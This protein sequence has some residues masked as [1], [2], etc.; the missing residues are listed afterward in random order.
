MTGL[1][2][3]GQ[4]AS[5]TARRRRSSRFSRG[6]PPG[7]SGAERSPLGGPAA[8]VKGIHPARARPPRSTTALQRRLGAHQEPGR[9]SIRGEQP[10]TTQTNSSNGSFSCP[11]SR[12]CPAQPPG[13][14]TTRRSARA[15]TTPKPSSASHD[16]DPTCSTRCSARA[17]STPLNPPRPLDVS[18][19]TR[20][21]RDGMTA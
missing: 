15:S 18:R 14:T 10:S 1:P 3:W 16:T 7:P 13:P 6:S 12:P 11:R 9:A 17:P 8:V 4:S 21:H 2:G 20:R 5:N 19:R